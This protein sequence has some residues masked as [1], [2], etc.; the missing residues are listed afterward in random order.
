M[1]EMLRMHIVI[2]FY[3]FKPEG[4]RQLP[5]GNMGLERN[6]QLILAEL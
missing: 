6:N 1:F 5:V 2:V 4:T 3:F